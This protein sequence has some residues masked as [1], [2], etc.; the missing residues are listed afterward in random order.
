M[1]GCPLLWLLSGGQ[2]PE[3]DSPRGERIST[4]KREDTFKQLVNKLGFGK[5]MSV[6]LETFKS[7]QE[8]LSIFRT[9]NL[10]Y[11]HQQLKYRHS[12]N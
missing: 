8:Y 5:G 7:K 10:V 9:I 11:H 1:A 3:S 6:C 4:F 12:P 2:A